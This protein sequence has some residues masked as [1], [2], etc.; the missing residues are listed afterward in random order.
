MNKEVI[1]FGVIGTNN[2]TDWFLNGA[3]QVKD[4]ILTAVYSRN[5]E[6]GKAF[7]EK[8]NVEHIFTDLF[9]MAKSDLIDAVYIASPNAIHAEQAIVFLNHKKHVLCEKALASNASQVISMINAAKINQ[10]ILME[11]MKTTQL[12]NF[13]I[14]KDNLHRIGKVRKYFGSYCQYSSRYDKYREGIVLNAFNQNLSN[15]GLMDIGVYCIHPMINLF[16][17]PKEIK[18]NALI[19]ESGVD[20]EGSIIFKYDEMDAIA[21]YSKITN[22]KLYSEIQGEDGNIIIENINKFE[23]V[24]IV[25]RDGKEEDL[26]QFHNEHDMCYEIET[27]I[28]MIKNGDIKGSSKLL[29]TSKWVMET[30]DEARKQIGL[31]FP[32]DLQ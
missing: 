26:T 25:F 30:M 11:A 15:G 10:V 19:L 7:A 18:A 32:A 4:F 28:T 6:K 22:S 17:K 9:E 27:F 2:I 8:Y 21:M 24:K 16:G 20:G 1:R 3:T 23:K 5:E 31:V 14:I 13:K 29:Q 12:P